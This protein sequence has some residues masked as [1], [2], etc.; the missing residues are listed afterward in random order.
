MVTMGCMGTIAINT[1]LK[2]T[3]TIIMI[4]KKMKSSLINLMLLVSIAGCAISPGLNI[5]TSKNLSSKDEFIYIESLDQKIKVTNIKNFYLDQGQESL[6]YEIGKGDQIAITIW[7]I[8]EIFP[9]S[10]I[11]PD[12][13]LRRVDSTGNIYFPYV[14]SIKAEGKTQEELRIDLTEKLSLYFND[15]QLDL[16]VARFNSQKVYILGEVNSPKK[17]NISDIPLT[18]SDA[19]GEVKGINNNTS[20]SARIFVIRNQNDLPEIFVA[21]LSS[22]DGFI[23]ASNFFLRNNDIVYVNANGTTQWNR[24]ISQFF[25]FSTFLNSIDNLANSD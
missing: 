6:P 22:A 4:I 10:N 13:N 5:S 7:G 15:P 1:M 25:P 2:N 8:Q 17:L 3:Y 14:G 21:D 20:N 11:N 23:Y 24:V 18:L 16:T 12:Q 19:L 9:I